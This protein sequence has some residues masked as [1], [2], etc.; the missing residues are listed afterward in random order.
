MEASKVSQ[1]LVTLHCTLRP[2]NVSKPCFANFC[3]AID[4]WY[5]LLC[6][7]QAQQA[8]IP[9]VQQRIHEQHSGFYT[10]IEQLES[11]WNLLGDTRKVMYAQMAVLTR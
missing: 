6:S 1:T 11:H 4:G 8:P 3:N 7:E 2:L 9:P 10:D 5:T